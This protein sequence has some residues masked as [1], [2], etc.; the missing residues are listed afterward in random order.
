MVITP[1]EIEGHEF[2]TK[3]RGLDPEDV[4]GFLSLVAEEFEKLVVANGKLQDEVT[5]LRERLGELRERER[6]LKETM[7]TA[8]KMSEEMK[9]EANK[10]SDL[11]V[12]EGEMKAEH[13][14]AHAQQRA[15]ELESVISD[16]KMERDA[17]EAA[18]KSMLEQ[19][20]KLIDMR[21]DDED[22]AS[23]LRFMRKKQTGAAGAGGGSDSS[24]HE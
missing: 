19:H 1:L 11:I 17:V 10:A 24:N 22:L 18:L 16:L 8:Q 7:L 21:R 14:I 6:M 9:S 20:L 5:D 4:K 2:K 12:K 15:S 3:F 13:L 23:R